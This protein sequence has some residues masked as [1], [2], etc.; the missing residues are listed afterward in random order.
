MLSADCPMPWQYDMCVQ[1]CVQWDDVTLLLP[2]IRGQVRPSTGE[3]EQVMRC[4]LN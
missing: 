1:A 4:A 2:V 3:H